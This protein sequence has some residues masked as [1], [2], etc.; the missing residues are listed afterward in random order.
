MKRIALAVAGLVTA[1]FAVKIVYFIWVGLA[2]I[3]LLKV[4]VIVGL[5][6][7]VAYLLKTVKLF[8]VCF[9]LFKHLD[10]EDLYY[11]LPRANFWIAYMYSI[12]ILQLQYA[13]YFTSTLYFWIVLV[14][15]PVIFFT[16][17]LLAELL[18]DVITTFVQFLLHGRY[19]KFDGRVMSRSSTRSLS[20]HLAFDGDRFSVLYR[21]IS[22]Y[23]VLYEYIMRSVAEAFSGRKMH[24]LLHRRQNGIFI[25]ATNV[26]GIKIPVV[27]VLMHVSPDQEREIHARVYVLWWMFSKVPVI[28]AGI[29][30]QLKG[31]YIDM[32]PDVRVRVTCFV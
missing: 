28:R 13:G 24:L 8:I 17:P 26:F 16:W 12:F 23:D 20:T 6:Y 10:K 25:A 5:L 31:K 15:P 29:N 19:L 32:S 18:S 3:T 21:Q 22:T 7:L 4:T 1:A 30:K 11:I 2:N 27:V 9:V 14:S